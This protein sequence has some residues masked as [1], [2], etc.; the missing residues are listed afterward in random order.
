MT[1]DSSSGSVTIESVQFPELPPPRK[2]GLYLGCTNNLSDALSMPFALQQPVDAAAF[3]QVWG[4]V[5]LDGSDSDSHEQV[6]RIAEVVFHS[7]SESE[8]EKTDMSSKR[9]KEKLSRKDVGGDPIKVVMGGSPVKPTAAQLWLEGEELEC[10]LDIDKASDLPA[11]T[12]SEGSALHG[13]G[14]CRPC[15]WSWKPTGCFQGAACTFCHLCDEDSHRQYKKERTARLKTL[16]EGV[17]R[18]K[19]FAKLEALDLPPPSGVLQL[20][21]D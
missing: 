1:C 14:R 20:R 16:R 18:K 21:R 17:K 10:V 3:H 13:L 8:N 5:E 19:L 6:R 4:Q 11:G 9:K 2:V 12:W 15:A 7:S